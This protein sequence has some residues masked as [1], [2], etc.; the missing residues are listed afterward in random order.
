MS[1]SREAAVCV[2]AEEVARIL[3]DRNVHYRVYNSSALI[4]VLSQI[5]L[6]HT[7]PFHLFN[8]QLNVICV[9]ILPFFLQYLINVKI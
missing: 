3:W 9:I 1:T 8:I 6:T 5:K 2:A 4:P 7:R